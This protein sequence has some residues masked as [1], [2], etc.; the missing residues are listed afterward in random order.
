MV[1]Y[2]S[3]Y[4]TLPTPVRAGYTFNGWKFGN[5]I[6]TSN[7][8]VSF[9][10][11][12]TLVAQWIANAY[13]VTFKANGGIGSDMTA[14]YIYDQSITLPA[15][16]FSRIDHIFL[17]WSTNSS[18]ITPTYLDKQI[19][20]NIT[21]NGNI[22]LYAIWV[23]TEASTSFTSSNETRDVELKCGASH[24][25]AVYTGMNKVALIDNGYKNIEISIV[26]DGQK[27]EWIQ[28]NKAQV[29]VITDSG[30]LDSSSW[31]VSDLPFSFNN[32]NWQEKSFTFTI[33]ISK[34]NSDG[35]F[36]LKWSTI[37]DGGSAN[38]GWNL[39]KTS[40]SISAKK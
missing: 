3:N 30:S 7:T 22:T 4:G 23:R 36:K 28:F 37:A 16:K 27:R 9:A 13:T 11:S 35:S 17:G 20:K 29:E 21:T 8:K 39:G 14:G 5:N 38:D 2:D 33:D 26:F 18:A 12:H 10:G 24:T 25:E 15:N 19:V 6:I 34:L 40:V 1:T 32:V 31:E